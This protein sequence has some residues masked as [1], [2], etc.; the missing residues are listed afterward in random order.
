VQSGLLQRLYIEATLLTLPFA[1]KRKRR[2]L[3]SELS[4]IRKHAGRVRDMDLMTADALTAN[5]PGEEDC[6]IRLMEYLGAERDREAK[7]LRRTVKH[8]PTLRRH[9][10]QNSKRL[11]KLLKQVEGNPADSDVMSATIAN[12]P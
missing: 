8:L 3:V 7:Q 4:E 9:L 2:R 12:H 5:P 11:E 6:L 1:S 10:K